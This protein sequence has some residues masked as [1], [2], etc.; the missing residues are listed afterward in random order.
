MA[1]LLES[2]GYS[3]DVVT[4]LWYPSIFALATD[5]SKL[6]DK[7]VTDRERTEAKDETWFKRACRDYAIGS[8]YSGPWIIA[9][10]GLAVFG[11][12]LWSSLSTPLHL[13]TAIAAGAYVGLV[14]SGFF[15]QSIARRLTFYFLQ[16]NVSMM[17]WTLDRFIAF[18][19][20]TYAVLGAAGW[21]GLR[22]TYGDPD[23]WLA[24]SFFV[25]SGIFQVSLA[26][27]YTMRRFAWIVA[28]SLVTTL[29]T[30]ATF[31]L[32]FHRRVDLPWE[33]A[34][35]AAEVGAVGLA[36][37]AATLLWVHRNVATGADHGSLVPPDRRAVLAA[38]LPYAVY[39]S[40]YFLM[41]VIDHLAAGLADGF[42]FRYRAGYELGCDVA[43]V[44]I[45]PVVGAVN[46]V[47][48]ELPRKILASANV[49][50]G[51]GPA[52]DRALTRY[53]ESSA[54]IV[55]GAA[56]LTVGLAETFG[57][58]LL[59]SPFTG[60]SGP[61]ADEAEI[62]LRLAALAYGILML[63]LLGAQLLFFVSRPRVPVL[64]ALA[65]VL[66]NAAVGSAVVVTHAPAVWCAAG[67][68]AATIT[69]T[70]IATVAAWHAMRRFT[71][72]YYA[73]Y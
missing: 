69:F 2:L 31:V 34:T 42:P 30:G 55:L 20:V 68:L 22:S 12:A 40:A 18:T 48:E 53:Y 11:A 46:A 61:M 19:L 58:T 59:R 50:L 16:E 17:A 39:G 1:I 41:I 56:V 7:Y 9:I 66:V 14:V 47:L 43:L 36:V 26:P 57:R 63:G 51:D 37:M 13:A 70:S 23:A 35:L 28:I 33:P 45:I 32:F 52:F 15:S 38:S 64:A 73:A 65:G 3:T 6:V 62:V 4:E 24:A 29:L 71:Y 49:V 25:G 27:L 44:A 60:L 5:V 8:L 10:L 67:L 21:L 54:L 72:S